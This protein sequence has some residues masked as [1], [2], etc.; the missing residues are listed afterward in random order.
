MKRKWTSFEEAEAL[1][2]SH[3]GESL[4]EWAMIDIYHRYRNEWKGYDGFLD[5]L[6]YN[7]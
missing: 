3:T 6:I 5:W 2:K 7:E 4:D 1:Y